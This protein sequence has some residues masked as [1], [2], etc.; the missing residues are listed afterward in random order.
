MRR[1]LGGACGL[2][3]ITRTPGQDRHL[4]TRPKPRGRAD[5]STPRTAPNGS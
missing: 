2:Q 3:K 5:A 1:N 4:G